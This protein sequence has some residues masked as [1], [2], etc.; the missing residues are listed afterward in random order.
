MKRPLVWLAAAAVVLSLLVLFLA[1]KKSRNLLAGVSLVAALLVGAVSSALLQGNVVELRTFE[2]SNSLLILQADQAV[3]VDADR[4]GVYQANLLAA[5]QV[6]Y[7]FEQREAQEAALLLQETKPRAALLWQD[8]AREISPYLPE[9]ITLLDAAH[10]VDLAEGFRLQAGEGCT[11]LELNGIRV[12]KIADGYVIMETGTESLN[13]NLL[14]DGDGMIH[15][16]AEQSEPGR[17]LRLRL[18]N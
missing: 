6:L 16:L 11:R 5:E 2:G 3:L 14:V 8:T 15:N 18:P 9:T 13:A 1:G 10:P 4:E 17:C 7:T 12:L